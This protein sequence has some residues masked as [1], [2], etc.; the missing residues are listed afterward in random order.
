MSGAK[1]QPKEV[2]R[3]DLL[4]ALGSVCALHRIAFAGAREFTTH[5]LAKTLRVDEVLHIGGTGA[6][7]LRAVSPEAR[8]SPT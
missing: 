7:T 8:Q 6:S 4:W 2:T 1:A 3:A 5:A